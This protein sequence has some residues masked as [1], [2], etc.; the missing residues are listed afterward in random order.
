MNR[1][2]LQAFAEWVCSYADVAFASAHACLS[3]HPL[4][5]AAPVDES[6]DRSFADVGQCSDRYPDCSGAGTMDADESA[7]IAL[8]AA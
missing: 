6:Y 7:A 1:M 5:G 2:V 8:E 3:S 4:A